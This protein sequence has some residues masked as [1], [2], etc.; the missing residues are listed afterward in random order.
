[1]ATRPLLAALSAS[2]EAA[3]GTAVDMESVGGVDAARRIDGGEAFDVVVLAADAMARLL[4]AG[5]LVDGS[6]RPVAASD[7]AVAL[8]ADADL[9]SVATRQ[10]LIDTLRAAPSIGH[11][12]GPSG[13]ALLAL[14]EAW[15][16][17]DELKARLVEA[18][19][20][21]PVGSLV[22]EGRVA[23]GFQQRSELI[24]CPGITVAPMPAGA[25]ITTVFS[26]G[27][28][29]GAGHGQAA[30]A[31]IDYLASPGADEVRRREGL[32]AP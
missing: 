19:P 6:V 12:T 24:H 9:A 25:Q 21:T 7:M 2:W 5:R 3:S 13:K 26:A 29:R 4:E 30:V 20:G 17:R 28:C 15:G 1:M 10:A 8:A 31:F 22:A 23:V 18:P 16:L 11:S 32:S 14:L 27:V